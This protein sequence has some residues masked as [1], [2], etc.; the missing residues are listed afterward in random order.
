MA[1]HHFMA[2]V[3]MQHSESAS[4]HACACIQ[5]AREGIPP[6]NNA[7][8]INFLAAAV[9]KGTKDGDVV[10]VVR[11]GNRNS[12]QKTIGLSFDLNPLMSEEAHS[13]C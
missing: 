10:F 3:P 1:D 4:L 12:W 2:D 7:K 9:H 6:P 13:A 11:A 8:V 5:A